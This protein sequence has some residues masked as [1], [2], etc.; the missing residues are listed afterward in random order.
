MRFKMI[1]NT[2][3]FLYAFIPHKKHVKK[4]IAIFQQP[5]TL[6]MKRMYPIAISPI[7]SIL[8]NV[9]GHFSLGIYAY[10]APPL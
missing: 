5:L 1:Y 9:S 7:L 8:A 6:L 3:G 10:N 4:S 2:N